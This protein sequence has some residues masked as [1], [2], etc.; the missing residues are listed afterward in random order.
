M[1]IFLDIVDDMP[2][3]DQF[4][5]QMMSYLQPVID[6]WFP[7]ALALFGISFLLRKI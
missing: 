1:Y 4:Q 2:T 3:R 5:T 6:N 7:I